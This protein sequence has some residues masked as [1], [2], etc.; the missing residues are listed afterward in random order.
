MPP[1]TR[2][3]GSWSTSR[4][5]LCSGRRPRALV[6]RLFFEQADPGQFGDGEDRG[7]DAGVVRHGGGSLEHVRRGDLP[8]DH[9]DGRQRHTDGVGRIPR[10]EHGRVGGALEMTPH[11]HST[12]TVGNAGGIQV[13]AREVG[14]AT[15]AVHHQ[16]DLDVSGLTGMVEADRIP[17]R[18]RADRRDRGRVAPPP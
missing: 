4:W 15:R 8:L 13:K 1:L 12:G 14:F 10:C 3:R 16:V 17:G 11:G 7:R 2:R 6:A 18:C 5:C 9:R